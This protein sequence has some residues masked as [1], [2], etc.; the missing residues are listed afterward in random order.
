MS[1]KRFSDDSERVDPITCVQCGA[2]AYLV[3][4]GHGQESPEAEILTFQCPQCGQRSAVPAA[5]AGDAT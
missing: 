2:L 1:R 3:L 5:D 4:R